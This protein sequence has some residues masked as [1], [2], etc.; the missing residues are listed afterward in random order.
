MNYQSIRFYTI[1]PGAEG[2]ITIMR[3]WATPIIM[4]MFSCLIAVLVGYELK[5]EQEHGNADTLSRL[6]ID[7]DEDFVNEESVYNV[8]LDDFPFDPNLIRKH[9]HEDVLLRKVRSLVEKIRNEKYKEIHS[10]LKP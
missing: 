10:K 4:I 9:V 3:K 5:L 2:V 8:M 6:P 7:L 1:R